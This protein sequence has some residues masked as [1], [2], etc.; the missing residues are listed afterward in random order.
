MTKTWLEPFARSEWRETTLASE[1]QEF[2]ALGC[3]DLTTSK[4][5]QK[6]PVGS[7]TSEV[8]QHMVVSITVTV[9]YVP[10]LN[11]DPLTKI[12]K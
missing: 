2:G 8:D 5:N 12:T 11:L 4:I 3:Y 10:P 7:I 6:K 1:L 9:G